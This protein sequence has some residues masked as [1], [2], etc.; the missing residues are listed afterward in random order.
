MWRA[1]AVALSIGLGACAPGRVADL[2]DIGKLSIGAGV[3]ASVDAS[4]GFVSQPSFGFFSETSLLGNEA[5]QASG[6]VFQKRVSFPYTFVTAA[7]DG[8]GLLGALNYTGFLATYKV[9]GFQRG[10]EEIDRTLDAVAPREFGLE[11]E[12]VRYGGGVVGGRWL[13]LPGLADDYSR[14]F[15]FHQL[16]NFHVGA[17]AGIIGARVG[18]NPLELFDFLLGLGGLDIAGDDP[19]GQPVPEAKTEH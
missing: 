18:F 11:I 4:L 14:I 16:T 15:T 9:T 6:Y 1:I 19:Q 12:G 5:R 13:P 3:G 2:Q 7:R 17:H 8:K 10:F